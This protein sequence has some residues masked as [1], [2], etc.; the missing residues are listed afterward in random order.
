MGENSDPAGPG[1]PIE[2]GS[3]DAP[4]PASPVLLS[5]R[6]GAGPRRSPVVLDPGWL[7]LVAGLVILAATVLIPAQDDLAEARWLRDRALAVEQHRK[8]RLARYEEYL[9]SLDDA[10]QSLIQSLAA[11]Q[12]NQIPS[13]RTPLPGSTET[14]RSSA[15]VFPALEPDPLLLQDRR[16]VDSM[17]ER[18]TTNDRTRIWLIAGGSLCVLIGLLPQALRKS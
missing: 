11:M 14:A 6:P 12:L 9:K 1:G 15:S 5:S 10:D 18:L 17:L 3:M 4:A 7:F 8:D 16:K 2:A 13:D